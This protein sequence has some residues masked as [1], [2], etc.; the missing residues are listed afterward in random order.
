M[1]IVYAVLWIAGLYPMACAWRANRST[2]LLHAV[3]W[4]I[5]AWC[6]WGWALLAADPDHLG[7]E[8]GRYVALCATGGAGVAVLGARRPHV[9]AWN[10]VVLGLL[11][12][13]QLPLVESLVIGTDPHDALRV[14]FLSATLAVG[15]CNYLPTRSAPAVLLLAAACAGE[16]VSLFAPDVLANRGEIQ[17]FHLV[18][19]LTTWG[20]WACWRGEREARSEFDCV[21]LDFRDRLGLLWAQRVR[22]QFNNAAVHAGWMVRLAWRGL[23][24]T[25]PNVA[26]PPTEQDA[27]I[28]TLRAALKR[29]A[30]AA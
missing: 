25:V 10:F 5:V 11:A 6:A 7:L 9:F 18:L 19:L 21:W 20:A 15:L 8:P 22:E 24:R 29:F 3:G 23:H 28:E 13:M 4:A 27:M 1:S 16:I 2:S 14:L 26:I 12:V 30:D 17:L